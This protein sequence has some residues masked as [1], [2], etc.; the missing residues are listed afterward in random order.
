MGQTHEPAFPKSY[1]TDERLERQPCDERRQLSGLDTEGM[2]AAW[3]SFRQNPARYNLIDHNCSTIIASLLE[4]VIVTSGGYSEH[5]H[6]LIAEL[7]LQLVS[8]H[9]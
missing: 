3:T 5:S 6:E 1:A 4:L 7:A 9:D 8:C 2:L